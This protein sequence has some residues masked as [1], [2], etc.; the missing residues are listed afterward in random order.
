MTVEI[1]DTEREVFLRSYLAAAMCTTT[2]EE[3]DSQDCNEVSE[4]SLECATE[5]CKKFLDENYETIVAGDVGEFTQKLMNREGTPKWQAVMD[6]AGYDFWM[7]RNRH[8]VGFWETPDWPEEVGE[9][10]TEAAHKMG[11]VDTHQGEGRT[12]EMY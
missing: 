5:D 11:E 1:T 4:D 6:A 7:T 3:D 12:L 9:K 2:N 8:G 10:L